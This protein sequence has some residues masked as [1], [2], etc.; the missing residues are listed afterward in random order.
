MLLTMLGTQ[1]CRA[2]LSSVHPAATTAAAAAAAAAAPAGTKVRRRTNINMSSSSS[3][4]G[5]LDG[6]MGRAD[7]QKDGG[8]GSG[9]LTPKSRVKLGD[10]S[11]SPMGKFLLPYKYRTASAGYFQ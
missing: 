9:V 2:F 7:K 5:L 8:S 1:G 4:R 6:V 3:W 10:L 11:V